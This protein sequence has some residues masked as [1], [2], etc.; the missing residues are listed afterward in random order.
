[1]N[2]WNEL[3]TGQLWLKLKKYSCAETNLAKATEVVSR[4][5]GEAVSSPMDLPSMRLE[6][7]LARAKVAS[8]LKQVRAV[9]AATCSA[10]SQGDASAL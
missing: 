6:I 2:N 5:D 1:M 10:A 4:C 9:S 8:A 7:F 3:K